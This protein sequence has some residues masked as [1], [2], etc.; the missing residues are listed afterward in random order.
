MET[1]SPSRNRCFICGD[2]VKLD[3]KYCSNCETV[4]KCPSCFKKSHM[5]GI[6]CDECIELCDPIP[7]PT[8]LEFM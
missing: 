4:P 3:Q 1:V 2:N 7:T 8:E 5:D 6:L